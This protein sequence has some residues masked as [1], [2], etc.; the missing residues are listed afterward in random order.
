MFPS[1]IHRTNMAV[2]HV[3]FTESQFMNYYKSELFGLTEFLC[4]YLSLHVV[5]NVLPNFN[6]IWG[7]QQN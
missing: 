5:P 1:L 4:K 3:F 6:H 2:V 7:L